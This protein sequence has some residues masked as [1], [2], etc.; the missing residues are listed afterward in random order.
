MHKIQHITSY[1]TMT[2]ISYNFPKRSA[3]HPNFFFVPKMSFQMM[4]HYLMRFII[5]ESVLPTYGMVTHHS[6]THFF[7]EN[8]R[9]VAF[10]LF[11]AP[12]FL[13]IK[14][15][16]ARCASLVLLAINTNGIL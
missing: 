8:L 7:E 10:L 6:R 11:Q 15:Y 9:C 2:P 1:Q 16:P 5:L 4:C 13:P 12:H 14:V 3:T